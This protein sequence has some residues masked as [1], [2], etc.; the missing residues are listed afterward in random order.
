MSLRCLLMHKFNP[1]HVYCRLRDWGC[2]AKGAKAFCR[3]YERT[4]YRWIA[5]V[6][7]APRSCPFV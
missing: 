4:V 5:A 1:L 7:A 2:G 3:V 6:E